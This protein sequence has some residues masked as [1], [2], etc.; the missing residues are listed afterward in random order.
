M[1]CI[2]EYTWN[3]RNCP[4]PGCLHPILQ[5]PAKW[6]F[7]V[8]GL[9]AAVGPKISGDPYKFLHYKFLNSTREN[10]THVQI[11]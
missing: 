4:E 1:R 7:N 8:W 9:V 10:Q 3:F 6:N 11:F 5:T 2:Q